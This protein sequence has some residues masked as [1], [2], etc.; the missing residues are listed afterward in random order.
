MQQPVIVPAVQVQPA[1]STVAGVSKRTTWA[2]AV[3]DKLAL[4]RYVAEH[5]EWVSLLDPN[6][7]ALNRLATTQREALAIPGVKPVSKV[8][9]AVRAS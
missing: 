3:Y 9:H 1:V 7:P 8:N 6:M 5:P 2:A 4:I